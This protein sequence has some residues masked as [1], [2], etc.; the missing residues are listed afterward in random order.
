MI[1]YS[2]IYTLQDA[3]RVPESSQGDGFISSEI[4]LLLVFIVAVVVIWRI[5]KKKRKTPIR[6]QNDPEPSTVPSLPSVTI[7]RASDASRYTDKL[8][9]ILQNLRMENRIRDFSIVDANDD[10][11]LLNYNIDEQD[12][13]LIVLT[14]QLES[15]KKQ[16]EDIVKPLQAKV[17]EI[18][19]DNVVYDNNFITFPSDLRPI[20][21]RDDKKAVWGDI[22]QSLKDMFP[23]KKSYEPGPVQ[24]SGNKRLEAVK[25]HPEYPELLKMKPSSLRFYGRSGCAVIFGLIFALGTLFINFFDPYSPPGFFRIVLILF[26]FLGVGL[27]LYGIYRLIKLSTSSLKRRPALVVDKRISVSGGAGSSSASTTYY[28]TVELDGGERRELESG[29]KLYG[30]ITKEDVGV[31]YIRDRYLLDYR[32][33]AV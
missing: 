8:Q 10:L 32:R 12:L 4:L 22:E 18:I 16:I 9:L 19:V 3:V 20:Y 6:E 11:S 33:L 26:T 27:I 25:N 1:F 29:G 28:V 7:I 31:A 17:A 24:P 30:K 14:N 5:V 15:Q 21:D 13:I 2:T 23:A